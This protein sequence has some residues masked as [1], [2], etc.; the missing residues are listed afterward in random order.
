MTKSIKNTLSNLGCGWLLGWVWAASYSF[1]AFSSQKKGTDGSEYCRLCHE[2]HLGF[3]SN[4]FPF[5][6]PE[7]KQACKCCIRIFSS[8]S[9]PLLFPGVLPRDLMSYQSRR[10]D[11]VLSDHFPFAIKDCDHSLTHRL[12]TAAL[13]PKEVR[14]SQLSPPRGLAENPIPCVFRLWLRLWP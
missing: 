1:L 5:S 4:T 12:R 11:S 10:H 6:F 13:T 14:N 3:F 9:T 2:R 7:H 8:G